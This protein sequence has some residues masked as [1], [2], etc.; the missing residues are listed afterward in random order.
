MP[1]HYAERV[2]Q[3]SIQRV[4]KATVLI[5]RKIDEF[6]NVDPLGC[7]VLVYLQGEYF[8]ITAAH[9][10]N[11]ENWGTL[12]M[13]GSQSTTI[14][15]QS[16]LCS[17]YLESKDG[18]QIDFS[19]LRFYPKMHKYLIIYT[20]ITEDEVMMNHQVIERY[21]Y[22]VSGYPIRKIKRK[23]KTFE[24][25]HFSFLTRALHRK[26]FARY[27]LDE[28]LH[29]L[30]AYHKWFHNYGTNFTFQA[31]NP[32]GISGSGLFFIPSF[33]Q[34]QIDAL[35]ISLVA[36]MI[37]NHV[38]HGFLAAIKIDSIMEVIR[39]QFGL[40]GLAIPFTNIE[41]NLGKLYLGDYLTILDDLDRAAG[42]EPPQEQSGVNR[43]L[44]M[45]DAKEM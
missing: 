18:H 17:S 6:V 27:G 19:I 11:T 8:L 41:G 9:L 35:Q 34:Q 32:Q 45:D 30:V 44:N 31:V 22:L 24:I 33:N 1:G 38:E 15:L 43:I 10:L 23:G 21:N 12:V 2:V 39:H 25:Q 36:V 16:E 37:E 20:P 3:L 28:K 14:N 5:S 29:C 42:V 7:G 4:L 26:K 40:H 13:P